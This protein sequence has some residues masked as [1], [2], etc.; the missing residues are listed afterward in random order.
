MVPPTSGG[1]GEHGVVPAAFLGQG[2]GTVHTPPENMV[3]L[4]GNL[5]RL[6]KFSLETSMVI[7]GGQLQRNQ[8][9]K[10]LVFDHSKE[11]ESLL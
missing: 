4:L 10:P 3:L 8:I 7:G 6:N 1:G 5:C 9:L 2:K 11:Y